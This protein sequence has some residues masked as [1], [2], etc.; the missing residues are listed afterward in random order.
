MT[1]SRPQLL[2]R[3]EREVTSQR[4]PGHTPPEPHGAIGRDEA[5]A[6]GF[7]GTGAPLLVY[8]LAAAVLGS[9]VPLPAA[10]GAPGATNLLTGAGILHSV[11]AGVLMIPLGFL[12]RLSGIGRE[13]DSAGGAKRVLVWGAAVGAVIELAQLLTPGSAAALLDVPMA[14]VGAWIGAQ[15]FESSLQRMRADGEGEPLAE[16]LALDLPLASL[17]YLLVPLMWLNSLA[18]AEAPMATLRLLLLGL[19]GAG[20]FVSIQRRTLAPRG[21]PGRRGAALLAAV[22]YLIATFPA[23][24]L[25]PIPVVIHA[26]VVGALCGA[27]VSVSATA[28]RPERRFEHAALQRAAPFLGVYLLLIPFVTPAQLD[29]SQ[30]FSRVLLLEL[31]Q[32]ATSSTLIGY[33]VAEFRGRRITLYR[34]SMGWVICAAAAVAG[35]SGWLAGAVGTGA[36]GTIRLTLAVSAALL[37]GW[38]YHVQRDRVL[39][40]VLEPR[41][42]G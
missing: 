42:T 29:V 16:I 3:R 32:T 22:A 35:V 36:Y 15:L 4:R 28:T 1:P 10:F 13:T 5:V 40:V 14:A 12:W 17:V 26:L 11:S 31:L 7:T 9:M 41:Q 2:G 34:D 24:V 20:V 39:A 19:F 21:F 38:L 23:L 33:M 18:L 30:I 8:M 27:L 25:R 37:G 6:R